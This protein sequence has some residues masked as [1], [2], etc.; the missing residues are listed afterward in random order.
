M[1]AGEKAQLECPS[2][3]AHGGQEVYSH[4]GSMKIPANSN[5]IYDLEVLDCAETMAKKKKLNHKHKNSE[6]KLDVVD[7]TKII[8]NNLKSKM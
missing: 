2:Y 8:V 3:Y 1:H 6:K 4:F 7:K 5:L